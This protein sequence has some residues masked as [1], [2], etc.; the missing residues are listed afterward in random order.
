MCGSMSQQDVVSRAPASGASSK[1]VSRA[2]NGIIIAAE[3][4]TLETYREVRNAN[5]GRVGDASS[6]GLVTFESTRYATSDVRDSYPIAEEN[7]KILLIGLLASV[8]FHIDAKCRGGT[9]GYV[10]GY[11]HRL[12]G[13]RFGTIRGTSALEARLSPMVQAYPLTV[14]IRKP[15]PPSPPSALVGTS[16]GWLAGSIIQYIQ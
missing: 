3:A 4:T 12:F 14:F 8:S 5:D 15:T 10:P 6:G 7:V 9:G 13:T 2:V 16:G 11:P 1:D